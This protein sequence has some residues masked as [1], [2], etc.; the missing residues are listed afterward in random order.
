MKNP[1]DDRERLMN[2]YE[3]ISESI[4]STSDDEIFKE[5]EEEGKNPVVVAENMRA[6]L[7]SHIKSHNRQ[8]LVEAQKGLQKAKQIQN[9]QQ[10]WGDTENDREDK[11]TLL[12]TLLSSIPDLSQAP[13]TVAFRD[14]NEL[15]DSDVDSLL[16]DLRELGYWNSDSSLNK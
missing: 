2:L 7:A 10:V 14:H 12:Q 15:S 5:C 8:R 3:S 13:L 9:S 4:M 1:K 6:I 11:R 16:E